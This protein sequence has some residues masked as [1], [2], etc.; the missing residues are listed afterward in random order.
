MEPKTASRQLECESICQL[1]KSSA[2]CNKGQHEPNGELQSYNAGCCWDRTS[3]LT[4]GFRDVL[5]HV[6]LAPKRREKR[7]LTDAMDPGKARETWSVKKSCTPHAGPQQHTLSPGTG[8]AHMSECCDGL[9]LLREQHCQ[10]AP[11]VGDASATT[12]AAPMI[13]AQAHPNMTAIKNTARPATCITSGS[14][15]ADSR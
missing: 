7:R 12:T 4:P 3:R 13:C 2:G 8:G 9:S 6:S 10:G 14:T 5:C 1:M 15:H 11:C